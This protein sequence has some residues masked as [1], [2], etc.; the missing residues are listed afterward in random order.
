MPPEANCT[1]KAATLGVGGRASFEVQPDHQRFSQSDDIFCRSFWDPSVRTAASDRFYAT[2]RDVLANWRPVDGFT[3]RDY[4]LRNASW[5]VTDVFAERREGEDRREGYLDELTALRDAPDHQVEFASEDAAALE[6]KRVARL[7][8]A[9]LV[10]ITDYDERWVYSHKYSRDQQQPKANDQPEGLTHV[11]V[12]AKA[13]DHDLIA[14]VPSALSGAATGWGYSADTLTLLAVAQYI[15]NLG[16]EAIP[17]LN[18]TALAIPYAIKA[19]LGEYGK[20]GLVITPEYGPRV[21][22][23]KIFT[24]LPMTTDTPRTFG[25]REF[26][27]ICNLCVAAC[28]VGAIPAGP[29]TTARHNRSNIVG[30]KKWTVDAEKCF[31]FWE[32]Q[33][34]DCSICIRVCPYNRAWS[35]RLFGLWRRLAGSPFRRVAYW[36]DRLV[37]GGRREVASA[38][39]GRTH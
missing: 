31:G 3:Q 23:G 2:Y 27:D 14:T 13:M 26:C 32:R 5:H 39:W 12:V 37:G 25:V 19:G 24:N 9:D 20:L 6:M 21:R 34:S 1:D 35:A 30:V 4:A 7:F 15:R 38:W 17:N 11:I 29:P 10:G 33:N 16:Y 18:D 8:G 22:F 28:P 36:L